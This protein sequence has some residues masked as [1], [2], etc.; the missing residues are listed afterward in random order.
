MLKNYLAC[1]LTVAALAFAGCAEEDDG[2][3]T[4]G[5]ASALASDA[6]KLDAATSIDG[7]KPDAAAGDAATGACNGLSY[8]TFGKPLFESYCLSCHS[9]KPYNNSYSFDTVEKIRA[10]KQDIV[11]H[12][13]EPRQEPKMPQGGMLPAADQAKLK[14][15]LDCGAP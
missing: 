1:G 8:A 14:A 7:G 15:W 10:K 5:D 2:D 3:T 13:V 4:T 6:G 11:D 12:A 9:E